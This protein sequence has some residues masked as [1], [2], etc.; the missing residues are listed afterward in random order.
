MARSSYFGRLNVAAIFLLLLSLLS[1]ATAVPVPQDGTLQIMVERATPVH[2]TEEEYVA[3]LY[4]YFSKDEYDGPATDR[5]LQYT[6]DSMDQV[7]LFQANN[8]GYYSYDD[9]FNTHNVDSHPWNEAF[10]TGPDGIAREDD[11][12]LS[13]KAMSLVATTKIRV[14]GG[15]EYKTKGVNS[16]YT[17]KEAEF[18]L[19]G[20]KDGRLQSIEHMAKD[21]TSP[22]QVMIKEDGDGNFHWQ[23]GYTEG[24][25]NN[26]GR[27]GDGEP[28]IS[29]KSS[30]SSSPSSNKSCKR[31][32]I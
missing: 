1:I 23:P 7:R 24:T 16:F 18:N 25:T 28:S 8:P 19:Q 12:D 17:S 14:F 30:R 10:G 5:Y 21:A 9:L 26:S 20:V 3:Y 15:A 31:A 22:D 2:I 27:F 29:P 13:C 11:A 32:R 6:A 4:K